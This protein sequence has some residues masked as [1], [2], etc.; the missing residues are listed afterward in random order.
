MVHSEQGRGNQMAYMSA[1]APTG[2]KVAILVLGTTA[3][4]TLF[5]PVVRLAPNVL[6]RADW[7]A[8]QVT[9]AM[10]SSHPVPGITDGFDYWSPYAAGLVIIALL[11]WLPQWHK[12]VFIAL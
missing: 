7:S 4:L 11:L 1:A 12:P 6:G 5:L 3:F 2:R 10:L 8:Y 9:M